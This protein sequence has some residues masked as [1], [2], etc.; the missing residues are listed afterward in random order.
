M[1]YLL[2]RP[3]A[4]HRSSSKLGELMNDAEMLTTRTVSLA[5]AILSLRDT[6]ATNTASGD[7]FAHWFTTNYW[8]VDMLCIF[9]LI[10]L[11]QLSV[12]FTV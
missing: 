7:M 10:F 12:Y 5:A 1:Q 6:L 2:R 11:V 4:S 3:Y 9:L 8:L